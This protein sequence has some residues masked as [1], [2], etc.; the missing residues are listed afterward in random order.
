MVNSLGRSPLPVEGAGEGAEE[1]AAEATAEA[2]AEATAEAEGLTGVAEGAMEG[3][4]DGLAEGLVGVDGA[5]PEPAPS[6]SAGPG[7]LYSVAPPY[8]LK[9]TS[10]GLYSSVPTTPAAGTAV[11]DPVTSMFKH[12]GYA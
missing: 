1:G 11:P 8:A 9:T 2:A 7:I 12:C 6:Q 4:A 5:D 10:A 3:T